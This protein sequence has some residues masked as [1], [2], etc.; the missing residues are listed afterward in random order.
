[1]YLAMLNPP[2]PPPVE[3]NSKSRLSEIYH[4]YYFLYN[5]VYKIQALFVFVYDAGSY[6]N[7]FM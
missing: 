3:Q 7:E 2:P 5:A 1:M 4:Y 6:Y